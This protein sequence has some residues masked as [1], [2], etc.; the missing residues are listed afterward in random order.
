[1]TRARVYERVTE[2]DALEHAAAFIRRIGADIR[3]G[4]DKACYLPKLDV[5]QL[6]EPSCF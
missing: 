1:M 3:Y 6:P 5:I 4:G 2:E